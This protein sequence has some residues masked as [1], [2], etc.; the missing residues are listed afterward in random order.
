MSKM[1]SS[2]SKSR[3]AAN[4]PDQITL[5]VNERILKE[6]HTIYTDPERGTLTTLQQLITGDLISFF[7]SLFS[8]LH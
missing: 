4:S 5:T 6:C 3:Q 7:L 1:N 2:G 8:C